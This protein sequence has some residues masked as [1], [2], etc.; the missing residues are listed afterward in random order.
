MDKIESSEDTYKNK[1]GYMSIY[2]IHKTRTLT[3]YLL[4]LNH[5]RISRENRH[6]LIG[7]LEIFRN[8][9]SLLSDNNTDSLTGLLNRK[10]FDRTIDKIYDLVPNSNEDEAEDYPDERRTR[11]DNLY[12]LVMLDIDDFKSINDRFGHLY[13]DDVLI[14]ISQI[15]KNNF[16]EEDLVFRFGGEE[17]VL[18]MR[19]KNADETK[20]V[21]ER[22][23]KSVASYLFPQV[24]QVTMSAGAACIKSDLFSATILDYADQ[25]LYFSKNNGKNQVTIY[26][27]LLEK[28]LIKE[29]EIQTGD[30]NFF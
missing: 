8:Y 4:V 15:I 9:I 2:K 1:S 16:R 26:E 13:G 22:L 29:Q 27:D 11:K 5:D 24:G 14:L 19:S 30:I 18:I 23:L 28:G 6:L 12:W 10:S 25:A 20:Y 17:F 3:L 21:L 7:L